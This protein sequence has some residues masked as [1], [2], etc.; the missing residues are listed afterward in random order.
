MA[1]QPQFYRYR[2]RAGE[3]R[4]RFIAANGRTIADSAEGYSSLTACDHAIAVI[5]KEA[6][7]ALLK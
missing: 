4:W 2:D 6:P 1:N 5:K 7:S 3:W